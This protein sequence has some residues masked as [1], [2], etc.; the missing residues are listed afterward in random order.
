MRAAVAGPDEAT[1]SATG[2]AP[3]DLAAP[4]LPSR[5]D[6]D[7]ARSATARRGSDGPGSGIPALRAVIRGVAALVALAGPA[8]A[9][10]AGVEGSC[11][12]ASGTYQAV[13]PEGAEEPVPAL[14]FLHGWGSTG[15]AMVETMGISG[16]ATARGYAF[17]APDGLPRGE[18]QSG[19]T[20]SFIPGRPERRDEAAFL[21]EVVADAVE[22]HGVDP[23]HVILGGFSIGGSMASYLA[24]EH[25]GDFAAYAPVSGSFWDPEP[26][27]CAGPVRL[28]HTHGWRDG[29]VPLEGRPLRPGVAQGDV[30]HALEIWRAANGCDGRRADRFDT[31]GPFWRRAWERCDEGTALELALF[32]G[33]HQVPPRWAGMALDWFEALD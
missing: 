25:P 27:G 24:C 26:E 14:V 22:R 13:L 5:P 16:V 3:A 15:E 28:L 10:C 18:G 31:S 2:G 23:D 32:D 9:D 29:T 8:T 4:T 12:V 21:R 6:G 30:F 17:L 19:L 11:E 1:R 7:A 20:W 33:G